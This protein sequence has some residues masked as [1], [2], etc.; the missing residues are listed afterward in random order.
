MWWRC[1]L[2]RTHH[3]KSTFNLASRRDLSRK[4]FFFSAICGRWKHGWRTLHWWGKAQRI[5]VTA[6]ASGD[7]NWRGLCDKPMCQ[8]WKS[9]TWFCIAVNNTICHCWCS[10]HQLCTARFKTGCIAL[11]SFSIF[12]KI[13]LQVNVQIVVF[14]CSKINLTGNAT[15]TILYWNLPLN[16]T[17]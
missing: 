12:K 11:P 6:P 2:I 14:L 16:V 1:A 4:E 3:S 17:S 13:F 5:G 15:A 10:L 8:E 9:Q 7:C